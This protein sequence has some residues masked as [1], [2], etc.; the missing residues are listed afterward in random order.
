MTRQLRLALASL[1]VLALLFALHVQFNLGGWSH[2]LKQ[3]GKK[4]EVRGE[5]IVGFLPVT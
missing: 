5:L 1:A 4:P 3:A 2:A